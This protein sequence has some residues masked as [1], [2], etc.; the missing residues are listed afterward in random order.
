[1]LCLDA[2]LPGFTNSRRLDVILLSYLV[3]CAV[4]KKSTGLGIRKQWLSF[5]FFALIICEIEARCLK[6]GTSD[7]LLP[8]LG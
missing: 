3:C 7:F 4:L 5:D 8:K 1:M 6:F 2:D